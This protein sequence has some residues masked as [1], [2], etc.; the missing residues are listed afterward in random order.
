ML[1]KNKPRPP[2]QPAQLQTYE[3]TE[4]GRRTSQNNSNLQEKED[5]G[6]R[7]NPN[8][9]KI[10]KRP[11]GGRRTN[12]NNFKFMENRRRPPHEPEQFENY[13]KT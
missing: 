11:D 12:Q 13:E 6:R 3:N 2:H 5:G 9:Y 1:R 10:T 8:N 7:T 4:G